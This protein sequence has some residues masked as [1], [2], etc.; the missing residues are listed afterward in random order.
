[1]VSTQTQPGP[2][3]GGPVVIWTIPCLFVRRAFQVSV[4]INIFKV[5]LTHIESEAS[6]KCQL[7]F[8]SI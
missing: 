2:V 3:C 7:L 8:L 4:K 5:F 1:M 6:N